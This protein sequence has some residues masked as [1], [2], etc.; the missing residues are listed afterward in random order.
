MQQRLK[1]RGNQNKNRNMGRNLFIGSGCNWRTLGAMIIV[2]VML[3]SFTTKSDADSTIW[4]DDFSTDKGWSFDSGW[5]RGQAVY[6]SCEKGADPADDHTATSDDMIIGYA[7]GGCYQNNISS[8]LWATSPIINCSGY[9]G[10]HL[11]FYRVLGVETSNYDHAY[12]D[13]Y[14]GST[15]QRMYSNSTS[16]MVE[17]S[18][19]AQQ[20]INVSAYANDNTNFQIRFGMG[21]TDSSMAGC[22]WNV[23]DIEITGNAPPVAPTL[24]DVPFESEETPDTT[25]CFEFTASDPDGTASI[26]YQIQWDNDP[27][28]GSPTTKTSD[29]DAGFENTVT[30]SDTSPFNE[31]ERIRFTIQSA[32]AL[33]NSAANTAYYWRVSAKDNSGEGGSGVWG[34]W[35]SVYS[36]RVNTS[37][38]SL[39][40]VQTTDQQFQGGTLD[41]TEIYGSH[42]V[43]LPTVLIPIWSDDFSTDK[44]WSFDSGWSRGQAVYSSCEKGADPADDHTATSDD[45]II[46][47]AIGG[48]Y[49]NDIS[50]TLWATSPI[51]NCSGY[52]GVHLTFY[53]VL[54]VETF[55]YDRAYI[56]VYDGSTWQRMYSNSTSD[57]VETSW[58]AQDID[59]SAYANGKTNFQIRFGMGP[60]DSSVVGCGWNIDDVEIGY[61]G[62]ASSGTIMSPAV[63]F[64]WLPGASSWDQFNWTEDETIGTVKAQLYYKVTTDCDTIVPDSDLPGNSSGFASGPV[65]ISSLN[66]TTYNRICLKA[67]LTKG[68]GTPYLQDWT[69][70]WAAPTLVTLKSFTATQYED[71]VLLRWKTG[72]EVNN[73]GFHV[74]REE[75]GNL[76]RLTPEPVAGTALLAGKG[77]R[78]TA[79][80]SYFWWD[81]SF[82]HELS[83]ISHQPSGW[84]YWLKDIDLSGKETMYGP[85]TPVLSHEPLPV[86]FRPEL[87]SEVGL[88]LQ[89][90]Y[91][92]YWKIQGLKERLSKKLSAIRY[93]LSAIKASNLKARRAGPRGNSVPDPLSSRPKADLLIQQSLA[94]RAA[95]KLLVKEEGWYRVTQPELVAAGLS[96]R[97]NPRYLQLYG[98]GQEEPIRVIG[99][100][101]GRFDP[102]DTIEFYGVGLDTPSTDT[103]VYWLV[104]GSRPGKRV[105]EFKSDR[106]SLSSTSF[107]YTVEKKDR[108]VYFAALR[109]GDEENFFGPVVYMNRVDQILELQHLDRSTA[110]EA[111]LEVVLQ[112][113]TE[114]SHRVKVLF[115]EV[116]VGEVTFEGQ[117]QGLFKVEVSQSGLLE[118]E[119]LVSFIPEGGEMDVSLLDFIRLTYWHTYTADDNGLRFTAQGGEQVSIEGFR[120]SGIRVFDI[121]EPNGVIEVLGKVESQKGGYAISF[122]VPG[123]EQR[124]LLAL[125]EEKVKSPEGITSNQPSSWHESRDGYDLVMIT[126]RDFIDTL[127]PLKKLR[128]SQGLKVALID[129]EDLYD[130]FNFGEKSPQAIKD[131]L[132]LA[133]SNWRKSPRFVLLVGDASYDPRNYLGLG[134]FDFLPTKLI[135][136]AYMETASDD[137]FVDFNNDGLPEMAVGRLSVRTLEEANAV[138]SK[139]IGYERSGVTREALFVADVNDGFDFERAS[140]E[141]ESL[142]PS[143]FT[144]RKIYRGRF[145]SDSEAKGV[146]LDGI[147]EGCLLVNYIGHGSVEVW[148]GDILTSDDAEGLINKGL[149]FFVNMTCFNG[150]FQAP[151]ADTLAEALLKAPKGGAIAVWTSSGMTEAG[152]QTVMNKELIRL[153]FSRERLTLGESTARAKAATGDQEVRKTWILFGDPTTRLK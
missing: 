118:G 17:T 33:S 103:R 153:L 136:T 88:R 40:W 73:L 138:V 139:I 108:T 10:V 143:S 105:H 150:F 147:N 79:G 28:F 41:S 46:G 35:S 21:P 13:V 9:T 132:T 44:G 57:M 83:A 106:G 56:D 135:D 26:I 22:G 127:Q 95:V 114:G 18:W 38:T 70:T 49:E 131:F 82:N 23:D 69:I 55:Y 52:T 89:E 16:D 149:S 37:L 86:Q 141:V 71:G 7:I 144:V 5:S 54:G 65:S 58:S 8:T 123:T 72:Y 64:D 98:E 24:F 99:E 61:F 146:L 94:S 36:F 67:T 30:P 51:I 110:E 152:G 107:P 102:G 6:S 80:H 125:A 84:R 66:T 137:W 53:R 87:L 14:D 3:I 68:S 77:T 97:I 20:D 15:W 115:N 48:C 116:E 34:P 78:L 11:K 27:S 25:P 124:T 93:Q 151:Y 75:N 129:V 140:E 90:R 133:K 128:E 76:V 74:Y 117:S 111:L 113:V 63:D 1:S 19:S 119:N 96:S 91:R 120:N 32:N 142:L 60:T 43:R 81:A 92:D 112:G 130:E 109:N 50:S 47:Y 42:Q 104:E 122:R 12:I 101:D 2:S 121:T 85:V 100:K 126:H 39:R 31:G 134:D 59:V 4:S 29:T 145:T 148:R 45:M 62:A